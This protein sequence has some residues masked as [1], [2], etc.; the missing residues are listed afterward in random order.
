MSECANLSKSTQ[1]QEVNSTLSEC[2]QMCLDRGDCHFFLRDQNDGECRGYDEIAVGDCQSPYFESPYYMLYQVNYE[3]EP[4]PEDYEKIA[5]GT[6]GV[7][8]LL[9][10]RTE[11]TASSERMT[12]NGKFVQM[13]LIVAKDDPQS[14]AD[15]CNL[16]EMCEFFHYDHN[17]G[18]CKAV[19]TAGPN[20]PEETQSS[21]WYDFYAANGGSEVIPDENNVRMIFD[22]ICADSGAHFGNV[23]ANAATE[24]GEKCIAYPGCKYF[25]FVPDTGECF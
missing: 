9:N 25:N 24:C 5:P 17:D 6:D 2:Y 1:L 3:P 12:T 15:I 22:G 19:F 16:D 23:K 21:R 8:L 4:S 7:A 10:A 20:C 11:C 14:C 18:E 13:G